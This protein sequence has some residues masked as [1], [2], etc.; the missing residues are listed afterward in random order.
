MACYHPLKGYKIGLT[1]NGKPNYYITSYNTHHV[2]LRSNSAP[3]ACESSYVSPYSQH[4]IYEFIEIPCGKCLGCRLAYSRMWA[5]R[6]MAEATLHE[7]S[8]FVT[9]TYNNDNVPL[10]EYVDGETGEIK[11]SM[12]LVKRDFQLFMKRLRKNYPY[13]NKIR[14]FMSGEYG[15]DTARPHY[16]AIL[17][18]LKLDDLVLY[19]KTNLG[20]NTFTSEFLSRCWENKGFVVVADVTWE[21]CAYTARYI[22]KKQTGSDAQVYDVYNL[23]PEFTLMSRKPGIAREFFEK[24]KLDYL[25]YG[26]TDISTPTGGRKIRSTKYF[27]KFLDVEYPLERELIKETQKAQ[28]ALVKREKLKKTSLS[29]LEMLEVSEDIKKNRIKKLPR[30]EI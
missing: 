11:K 22:L 23:Q 4:S 29:Y 15:G 12:T 16:H 21:T 2:E 6:C 5:D 27:D 1:E 26:E 7:Q 10:N 20:F 18:G 17:F 3:V 24:N 28:M 14:F 13:E 30:K 19:K 25:R 8:Y 9:F